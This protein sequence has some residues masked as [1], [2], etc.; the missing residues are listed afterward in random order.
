MDN[1]WGDLMFVDLNWVLQTHKIFPKTVL[2]VGAHLA[3]ELKYYRELGLVSGTFIEAS[4]STF[5]NLNELLDGDPDFTAIQAL[6]SDSDGSIVDFH[7]AS[8]EQS[9]S[10]L[11]PSGH[12]VEH[13]DVLF[14]QDPIQL[15]T[16][17]LDT[18]NLGLFDLIVMDV[19]G[20]ELK[21]IKGGIDTIKEAKVFLLEA[22]LGGLYSGDCTI[23]EIVAFL[24]PYGF[25]PVSLRIGNNRWGDAIFI[26]ANH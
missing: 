3:Q 10:L 13:P 25:S 18:L 1:L 8:N 16:Q 15:V 9:S 26:K 22:S 20:A 17:R 19:Q 14:N 4:P 23:N 7:I 11:S 24:T 2:H 12:L 6:L 21:V 5:S